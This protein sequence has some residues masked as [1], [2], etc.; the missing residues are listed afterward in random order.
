MRSIGARLALWYAAAS[1]ATLACLF[2]VGYYLLRGHLIHGLDLLNQS[3]FQQIR[4]HLGTDYAALSPAVIDERIRETTDYASVLFYIDIHRGDTGTIFYSG[5][6]N[7]RAIPDVKGLRR[8]DVRWDNGPLR[9]GEFIMAPYD[10]IVA[11][12]ETQ[13]EGVMEGYA[14]VC[15][16]LLALLLAMSV[17]IGFGLSNLALRPVRLIRATAS[18]IGSENLSERI[19]VPAVK[20]EI[21]DLAR[22]LNEMFDRLEASFNNVRRFAADASHEL[23]TPLS[24]VRLHAEK[25]LGSGMLTHDNEEGMQTVLE[26]LTRVDATIDELL[27]LSRAESRNITLAAAPNDPALLLANFNVDAQVL[28]EHYGLKFSYEHAGH[29]MA[30]CEPRWLRRVLLNLLSNA[31]NASPPGGHIRLRSRLG[32]ELWRVE[33]EDQGEGVPSA[34][35]ERIFDRFVRIP[36]PEPQRHQGS[37]LGLAICRSIIQLHRGRIFAEHA[38]NGRGLRV[39]FEIPAQVAPEGPARRAHPLSRDELAPA[40]SR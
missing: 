2:V 27:F 15:V 38:A 8:Y 24:L 32:G 39:V 29:G 35:F 23:K 40:E 3:E 4:A 11:T 37:G 21:S 13:V 28:A 7:G 14:E 17:A 30:I 25:V 31:I 10:V 33:I 20:D 22:L 9:V 16:A 19:A 26:E 12:P 6:L 36:S 18:H 34:E 5:N 1:T